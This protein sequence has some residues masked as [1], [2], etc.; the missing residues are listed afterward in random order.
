MFAVQEHSLAEATRNYVGFL[1]DTASRQGASAAEILAAMTPCARLYAFLGA[2]IHEAQKAVRDASGGELMPNPFQRW[3]DSY[4]SEGFQGAADKMETL[5]DEMVVAENANIDVLTALYNRAMD[6]ELR[7]FEEFY[8]FHQADSARA[9]ARLAISHSSTTTMVLHRCTDDLSV[10]RGTVLHVGCACLLRGGRPAVLTRY[11][12]GAP[13][14]ML[15]QQMAE[16][17]PLAPDPVNTGGG[18][19]DPT[20]LLCLM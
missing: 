15:S 16:K 2:K 19:A 12:R 4:A 7:F 8:G 11:Q 10:A 18:T 20:Q 17:L 9:N 14:L 1:L 13:T 3:I 5:L 6:L